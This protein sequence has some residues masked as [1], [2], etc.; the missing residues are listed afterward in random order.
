MKTIVL[1]GILMVPLTLL[2]I[3]EDSWALETLS[4]KVPFPYGVFSFEIHGN[5]KARPT[6][7]WLKGMLEESRRVRDL[8]S[9][10]RYAPDGPVHFFMDE[11]AKQVN[12]RAM[13][14]PHNTITLFDYPPTDRG[15]LTSTNQWFQVL[16]LHELTHIIHM[17]QVG[18]IFRWLRTF[19]GSIIKPGALIPPW[20][21]EGIAV[22]AESR[23]GH[24]GRLRSTLL[25]QEIYQKLRGPFCHDIG[26]LDNPGKYPFASYSYWAGGFFMDFLERKIPGV[27][28]CF[29]QSN[30]RRFPFLFNKAFK[31]C[32]GQGA[33]AL[34]GEFRTEF[35]REYEEKFFVFQKS[36]FPHQDQI[37]WFHGTALRG[38]VLYYIFWKEQEQFV[39]A[40]DGAS[41]TFK[42]YAVPH[43]IEFL[44]L[45]GTSVWLKTY[46]GLDERGKRRTYRLQGEQFVAVS[47]Q[48]A[49]YEFHTDKDHVFFRYQS[50]QWVISNGKGKQRPLPLGYGVF[51]PKMFQGRVFFKL[52]RE[53]DEKAQMVALDPVTLSMETLGELKSANIFWAASCEGKAYLLH[54]SHGKNRLVQLGG[55][56]V[57]A[58]EEVDRMVF[59]RFSR[60]AVF[61]LE[62]GGPVLKSQSCG[63]YLQALKGQKRATKHPGPFL[64]TTSPLFEGGGDQ[65]PSHFYPHF[66]HFLPQYWY[67]SFSS[68]DGGG[69]RGIQTELSD[70]KGNHR[71]GLKADYYSS[72][73]EWR[74]QASYTYH[75]RSFFLG[76]SYNKTFF[77]TGKL[78]TLGKQME[79]QL[80][81]GQSFLGESWSYE[82][83]LSWG[84]HQRT[85][86]SLTQRTD[87]SLTQRSSQYAFSQTW[88]LSKKRRHQFL[89][90]IYLKNTLRYVEMEEDLK[91]Y[92]GWQGSGALGT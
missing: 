84:D 87:R 75:S 71:L 50:F 23:F 19:F 40:Y 78:G 25:R 81:V 10:F 5:R 11:K 57:W 17:D 7:D 28:R 82:P 52:T 21:S 62:K 85:D 91:P 42:S 45:Q 76:G 6:M 20:V 47:D 8:L 56:S 16:V 34:F 63:K 66:R 37:S 73:E 32:A 77:K 61:V 14:F 51:K 27:I 80:F 12:G 4:G 1:K 35:L 83:V 15:E 3:F 46:V 29:V 69:R 36:S 90:H 54:G 31:E 65:S 79:S 55:S 30:A 88:I 48:Q 53:W 26:C 9:Y 38:S 44:Y 43:P 13:I 18:G 58:S 72:A 70:P 86:R 67:F 92:W 41:R 2:L 33:Q 59:V 24:F 49:E 68:S 60:E 22:W 64:E 89:N 39:G 74:P